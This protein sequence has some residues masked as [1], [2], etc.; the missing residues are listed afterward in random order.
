MQSVALVF[1]L[2]VAN[3]TPAPTIAPAVVRDSISA[4]SGVVT[5]AAGQPIAGAEVRITNTA[6]GTT[7][8]LRSDAN[9]VY[10]LPTMDPAA[11]YT[12]SV[13]SIGYTPEVRTA[14][15]GGAPD[16]AK[17]TFALQPVNVQLSP[18]SAMA[19][20]RNNR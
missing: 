5:D 16:V 10:M 13:R 18:N 1:S 11:D 9:G 12:V 4:V 3:P 7:A 20:K 17:A 8:I 14:V 2:L 19:F 6:T 15:H